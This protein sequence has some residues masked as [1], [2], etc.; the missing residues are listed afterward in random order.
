M[1]IQ[2]PLIHDLPDDSAIP[3][4]DL[5]AATLFT[6]TDDATRTAGQTTHRWADASDVAATLTEITSGVL[7]TVTAAQYASIA[8]ARD[9]WLTGQ[10]PT[11]PVVATLDAL[12]ATLGQGPSLDALRQQHTVAIPDTGSETRWPVFAARAAA[13]GVR[14]MVSL[15]LSVRHESLGVLNLYATRAH[16]FTGDDQTIAALFAARGAIA[17]CQAA[18]RDHVQALGRRDMVEPTTDRHHFTA[19]AVFD[20]LF[21]GTHRADL[22]LAGLI[23]RLVAEHVRRAPHVIPSQTTLRLDTVRA[24]DE[25]DGLCVTRGTVADAIVVQASGEVDM[26]TAPRLGSALRAGCAA[27][28]PPGP[29]VIDLTGIRFFSAAGLTQLVDIR[30]NCREREVTLRVV[31]THRSVLLPMRITGV[32]VLFDIAP[33]L[34]AAIRPH[35]GVTPPPG[36]RHEPAAAKAS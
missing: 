35:T 28:R 31:A 14:S 13:L 23:R 1:S 33:T 24:S 21:R 15:P 34:A 10:A 6:V 20:R 12:Q 5:A 2:P 25:A 4:R 30:R 16:A 7:A 3:V 19:A 22:S 29:L 27:A 32:D 26:S 8:W 36:T 11:D 18:E 17:L 9:R